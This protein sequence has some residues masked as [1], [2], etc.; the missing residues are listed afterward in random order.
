M[1]VEST[2]SVVAL[3]MKSHPKGCEYCGEGLM[4]ENHHV[5]TCDPPKP[6]MVCSKYTLDWRC[7]FC[8]RL[9]ELPLA[10]RAP[11]THLVVSW[12]G[13]TLVVRKGMLN[14]CCVN[15]PL[16]EQTLFSM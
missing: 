10:Y 11:I 4:G 12:S 2:N 3:K 6:L 16:S 15:Q 5:V 9:G 13:V 1:G 8:L 14:A 7:F